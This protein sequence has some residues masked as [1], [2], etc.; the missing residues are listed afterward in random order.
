[1]F[2]KHVDILND[3]NMNAFQI[4]LSLYEYYLSVSI[5]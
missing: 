3:V 2:T 1:M 5:K 4:I